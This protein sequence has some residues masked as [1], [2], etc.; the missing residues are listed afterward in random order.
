MVTAT[1]TSRS[2]WNFVDFLDKVEAEIPSSIERVY[3]VLDNLAAQKAYD[4]LLFNL[5]YPRWEFLFQPKYAA[6]TWP[7]DP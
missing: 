6:E 7:G 2:I 4:V 3:V 5:V 1:Y